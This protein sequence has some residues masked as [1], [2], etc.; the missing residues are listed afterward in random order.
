MM[1]YGMSGLGTIW[2]LLWI[3]VV[4]LVVAALARD[5]GAGEDGEEQ[6][7]RGDQRVGQVSASRPRQAPQPA[8][9]CAGDARLKR[10]GVRC[11]RST[12]RHVASRRGGYGN[13]LT[14]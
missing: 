2:A 12:T 11:D 13:D 5:A 7:A 6:R 1:G 3:V 10:V 4:G 14:E 9:L 8:D